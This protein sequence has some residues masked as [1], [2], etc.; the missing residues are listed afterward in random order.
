VRFDPTDSRRDLTGFMV[1]RCDPAHYGELDVYRMPDNVPGPA[2]VASNIASNATISQQISL[3]NQ[4]GSQI[5]LGMYMVPV[6]N[7]IVYVRPLYVEANINGAQ[8][9]ELRRVIVVANGQTVMEP[10]LREALADTLHIDVQTNEGST[11]TTTP[12]G[13][14]KPPPPTDTVASLLDQAQQMFTAADAALQQDPPDLTT[15]AKDLQAAR[16]LVDQAQKLA[17]QQAGGT[18]SGST[19]S[20]TTGSG[21][22]ST[23][24]TTS[25]TTTTGSTTTTASA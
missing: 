2:L 16:A 1:A 9:P 15:W 8:V 24:T 13:G 18:G 20:T 11:E 14:T 17:E 3:L 21:S 12:G 4:Q 10:T 23:T 25:S 6:G 7:T 22:G 19:T 5:K